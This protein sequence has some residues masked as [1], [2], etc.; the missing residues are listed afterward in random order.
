METYQ[1]MICNKNID[2]TISKTSNKEYPFYAAASYKNID[3]AGK[4]ADEA[5][6]KC[7]SVVKMDILMNS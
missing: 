1:V 2:I 5:R 7:E 4:T 3:G 6:K